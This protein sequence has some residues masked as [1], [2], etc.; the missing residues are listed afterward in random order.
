MEDLNLSHQRAGMQASG[1]KTLSSASPKFQLESLIG[2][3]HKDW[4]PCLEVD[5]PRR[6]AYETMS[7]NLTA[8]EFSMTG[9]PVGF[10][11]L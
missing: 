3:G 11:K 6:I 2:H 4:T 5:V 10:F 1:F 8:G 9:E 7:Y